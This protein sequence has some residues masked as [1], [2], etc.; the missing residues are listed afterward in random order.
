[1]SKGTN[2]YWKRSASG[3]LPRFVFAGH[4]GKRS[5][6]GLYCWDCGTPLARPVQC[7]PNSF[8]TSNWVAPAVHGSSASQMT[9]CPR[10][11]GA[12]QPDAQDAS[13]PGHAAGLALGWAKP[14]AE[15]PW[16]VR[17]ASS[18]LWA[19]E[20]AR[21][22]AT[23]RQWPDGVIVSEYER[24]YSASDFFDMLLLIPMWFTD[25]VGREFD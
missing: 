5:A 11:H 6:A 24:E 2:F 20:P 13:A 15:R 22:I 18:F 17:S 25:Q 23:L 10:C 4:I 16:G 8:C 14:L 9:E 21:T 3:N 19:Q 1:M 12:P 7:A